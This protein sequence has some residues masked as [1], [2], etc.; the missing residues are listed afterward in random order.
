MIQM[1]HPACRV[2]DEKYIE[3]FKEKLNYLIVNYIFFVSLY[4]LKENIIQWLDLLKKR[5]IDK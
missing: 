5:I 2:S 1:P 4:K 3:E